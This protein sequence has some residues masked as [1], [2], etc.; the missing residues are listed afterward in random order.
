MVDPKF[1]INPVN[2]TSKEK[3][4]SSKWEI[5]P[6][7]TKLGIHIKTSGNGNV[8]NKKKIWSQDQEQKSCRAKK[9]EFC[10]PTI[11]FSMVISTQVKPQELFD[12]NTHKWARR[13]RT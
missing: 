13:N 10:N 11:Y 12:C 1:V 4:I 6:N 7:M 5:S 8:F 3:N 9:D 2:P